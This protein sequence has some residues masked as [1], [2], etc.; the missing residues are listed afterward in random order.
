M[1]ADKIVVT[2]TMAPAEPTARLHPEVAAIEI[3]KS[4]ILSNVSTNAHFGSYTGKECRTAL[5][6]A[7]PTTESRQRG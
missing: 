5:Y 6:R 4:R 3:F 2:G 7:S 1:D